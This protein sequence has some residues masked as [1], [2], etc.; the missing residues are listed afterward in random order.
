[1]EKADSARTSPDQPAVLELLLAGPTATSVASFL[2]KRGGAGWTPPRTDTR[3]GR[4]P[5]GHLAPDPNVEQT[6]ADMKEM[7]E[8]VIKEFRANQG[9]VTGMFADAP[10]ILVTHTG[11]KTGTKR[12]NPLVY[13]RDGERIVLIASK[14]G[15]PAHPHWYLNMVANP[16]VTVELPGET[17]EAKVTEVAGEERERLFRAQADQMSNFDD[18][19]K[20]TSR[21]IPVLVLERI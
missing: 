5:A 20:A 19:A 9:T 17:F 18:Y 6:M 7:N 11:A 2:S 10:L 12:T 14:G 13:T 1:V 3:G 15:A 21:Q 4:V 8:N 16:Q